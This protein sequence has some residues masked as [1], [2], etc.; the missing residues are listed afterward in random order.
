MFAKQTLLSAS[1]LAAFVGTAAADPD[2]GGRGTF[3]LGAGFSSD[4]NF[5]AS[6]SIDQPSLFGSGDELGMFA[7]ISSRRQLFDVR[8]VDPHVLGGTLT[9]D[10]FNDRRDLPGFTRE[11]VGFAAKQS[12]RVSEHVSAWVGYRI[13]DVTVDGI[14]PLARGGDTV[15]VPMAA[16][17][18]SALS[19]GMTY[20]DKRSTFGVWA[21]DADRSLGSTY[22][23]GK[24]G[25]FAATHQP[26]GPLVLHLG[27]SL[28]ALTPDAPTSERFFLEGGSDVRGYD[29]GAFGP[30]GGA[31]LKAVG[32]AA[33]ELPVGRSHA[34][35]LEG[36]VDYARL[37]NM[38]YT[39]PIGTAH[40][41]G[42]SVGY[43]VVW[44]SPIGPIHADVAYPLD[45]PP[46]F[47]ISLGAL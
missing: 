35:S 47:F 43:G 5:I 11:G 38:D 7:R 37:S 41:S 27:G 10:M 29:I 13:E 19:A 4:E 21:E 32:H 23:F 44:R 17:T 34:L 22:G 15:Y 18:V 30:V 25:A 24:I 20:S 6:A 26:V 3:Q 46:G 42:M 16:G 9:L 36:F 40:A 45:G 28:T 33:L 39:S 8:F 12:Y 31:T 2:G 1:L 14:Q